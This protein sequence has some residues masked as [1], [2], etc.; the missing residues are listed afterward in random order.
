M[1]LYAGALDKTPTG[2]IRKQAF[3][4]PGLVPAAWDRE[5]AGYVV[6]R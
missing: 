3:K 5:R 4:D 2:K 6:P 1:T